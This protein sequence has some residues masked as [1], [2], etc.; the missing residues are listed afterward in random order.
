MDGKMP[1]LDKTRLKVS[2]L[3]D[4]TEEKQY[5]LSRNPADRLNAI[6]LNR[7]MVYGT[8]RTTSRLQRLLE[9]AELSRS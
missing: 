2:S 1:R 7:R 5:W 4:I 8:D 3:D 6:E 9:A